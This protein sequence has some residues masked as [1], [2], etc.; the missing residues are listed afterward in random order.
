MPKELQKSDW[1]GELTEAQLEYAANDVFAV[2]ALDT[3]L[4]EKLR[5]NNLMNAFTLEC[6]AL[7]AMAQMWRTGLHWNAENLQQRKLD[8]EYDIKGLAQEFIEKLDAALPEEHKLP[9]DED[10]S[11][12]LRAKDQGKLRDGTKKY[13]GFNINSP[14][15]LQDK[16]RLS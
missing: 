1:S 3:P 8:Y 16:L 2:M 12:N 10:G 14:K 4:G 6:R 11:F 7:P 13:A 5:I 15:Q 9:R